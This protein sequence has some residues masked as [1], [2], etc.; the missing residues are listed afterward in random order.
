MFFGVECSPGNFQ[1]IKFKHDKYTMQPSGM[2]AKS[3]TEFYIAA[4][5]VML[6]YEWGSKWYVNS[7]WIFR[8]HY[9][10]DTSQCGSFAQNDDTKVIMLR[11]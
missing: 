11:T 4:V 2:V 3:S 6:D 7:E 8:I 10:P 1:R 5:N 9:N